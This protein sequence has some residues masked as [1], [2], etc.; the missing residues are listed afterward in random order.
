MVDY[1]AVMPET[2]LY[3]SEN[4]DWILIDGQLS[5]N[6]FEGEMSPACLEDIVVSEIEEDEEVHQSSSDDDIDSDS[7][8]D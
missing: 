4:S 2:L 6:W 8:D 7:D 5:L 3:R 1:S